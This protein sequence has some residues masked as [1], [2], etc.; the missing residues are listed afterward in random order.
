MNFRSWEALL[1]IRSIKLNH[2]IGRT[3]FLWGSRQTGKSTL[4]RERFADAVWIDLLKS[5]EF[6]RYATQPNLLREELWNH[7]TS[8]FIVI[9]EVQKVPALLNEVHW[10]IENKGL[11]FALCGSSARKLKRGHGN[12]LGGRAL[13]FELFGLTS[14]ELGKGFN[15]THLLNRGYVPNHYLAPESDIRR[16]FESYCADYLTEEVAGEALVRNIPAFANFLAISALSDTEVVSFATFARDVGVSANTIK[17]YFAILEDTMIGAF[18]PAFQKRPKR[19]TTLSPKF[20]F[21]DVGVVNALAKRWAISPGSELFGKAFENWLAHE[22]R[23]YNQYCSRFESIGYWQLTTGVEVD[24]VVGTEK[25]IA[26][27]AK[28][29][30]GVNAG[31]LK[32]LRQFKIEYPEALRL[33]VVSL[34]PRRRTLEDGL[35]VW[36][37]EDFVRALWRGEFF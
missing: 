24:F 11:K 29:T 27:E 31:H 8:Q 19:R 17:E 32:G 15:L 4:L 36:P 33:I 34:D 18:L 14:E 23:S 30:K 12:L 13:R 1:F 10:L 2:S 22:L 37:Y 3:F 16:L 5:D 26:I 7:E 21:G 20:Y 35:E 9:D 25:P 28:S 6:A